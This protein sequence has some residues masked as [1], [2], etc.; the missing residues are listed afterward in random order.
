MWTVPFN[1][2][3]SSIFKLLQIKMW[4]LIVRVIRTLWYVMVLD[5]KKTHLNSVSKI[6]LIGQVSS[7]WFLLIE[8]LS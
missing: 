6:P 8:K 5:D 4:F 3:L 1:A 2:T 7:I